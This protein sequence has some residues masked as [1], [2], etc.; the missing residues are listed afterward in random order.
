MS[1][2]ANFKYLNADFLHECV[3][4]FYGSV[5]DRTMTSVIDFLH[6][7]GTFTDAQEY[8]QAVG[9]LTLRVFASQLNLNSHVTQ[10]PVVQD[11]IKGSSETSK[12]E[13]INYDRQ[14]MLLNILCGENGGSPVENDKNSLPQQT[15]PLR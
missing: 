2:K 7:G 13:T 15:I 14:E 4:D 5:Y 1:Y 3:G 6:V 12:Y 11:R 9:N 10:V 8:V